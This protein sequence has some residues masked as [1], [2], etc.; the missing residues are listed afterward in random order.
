V[1]DTGTV[2]AKVYRS[3]LIPAVNTNGLAVQAASLG[4]P[5]AVGTSI[6]QGHYLNA[7]TA[8]EPVAVLGAE[9]AQH[10]GI[11]RIWPAEGTGL[12]GHWFSLPAT[13]TPAILA[14]DIDPSALLAFPPAEHYLHFD[15]HPST[16]YLRADTSQVTAVQALLAAT[17]NPENPSQV[18]V[19]Q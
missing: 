4:L 1:Q 17:A 12:G 16:I 2:N 18:T 14:P 10:L 9:A 7:A 5:A 3:P 15:G 8:R 6:A 13:L 19:S 11:R